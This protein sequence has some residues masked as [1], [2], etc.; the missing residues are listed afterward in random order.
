MKE[1][2]T[3]APKHG[4]TGE[5]QS[6]KVTAKEIDRFRMATTGTPQLA[7]VVYSNDNYKWHAKISLEIQRPW[8]QWFSEA[9][10]TLRSVSKTVEW[11]ID[12][13][14]GGMFEVMAKSFEVLDGDGDVLF[15][16]GFETELIRRPATDINA[17]DVWDQRDLANLAGVY[18][19]V[20]NRLRYQR[21]LSLL[22]GWP[23]RTVLM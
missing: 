21:H 5:K 6:M 1:L 10:R 19:C 15:D 23:K 16:L 3:M 17:V 11:E 20:L 7:A 12:F 4:D 14:S 22:R 18:S 2:Q 9:N 8:A 13:V